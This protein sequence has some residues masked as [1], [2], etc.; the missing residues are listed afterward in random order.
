MTNPGGDE[1]TMGERIMR[2]RVRAG[3]SRA[4]LSGLIGRS[5]SWLYKVERGVLPAD[6]LSDLANLT[7]ILKVQLADLV[8][9][10]VPVALVQ[11]PAPRP[12]ETRAASPAPLGP[13]PTG[14]DAGLLSSPALRHRPSRPP[15]PLAVARMVLSPSCGRRRPCRACPGVQA[16]R[17]RARARDRPPSPQPAADREKEGGCSAVGAGRIV[18]MAARHGARARGGRP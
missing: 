11:A 18:T 4:Q 14:A 7:R 8:G 5:P 10:P 13:L 2:Y 12:V 15:R 9:E 17:R 6:R 3:L 1:R 16:G